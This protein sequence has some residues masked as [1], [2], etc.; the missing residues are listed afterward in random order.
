MCAWSPRDDILVT[1]GTDRKVFLWDFKNAR[2]DEVPKGKELRLESTTDGGS[3]LSWAEDGSKFAIGAK[4]SLRIILWIINT[5]YVTYVPTTAG[6]E[7]GYVQLYYSNGN[8]VASW[9]GHEHMTKAVKISG[10]LV[11]SVGDLICVYDIESRRWSRASWS[12]AMLID[13]EWI[14]EKQFLVADLN[15]TITLDTVESRSKFKEVQKGSLTKAHVPTKELHN[16]ESVLNI[17][18]RTR[19]TSR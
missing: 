11:L 19:T 15:G 5:H 12:P 18:S 17:S 3:C 6:S 16:Y 1:A 13:A 7:R 14:S 8:M 10:D 2:G 9:Q 4:N